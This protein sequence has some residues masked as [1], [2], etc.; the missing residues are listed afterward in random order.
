MPIDD[1]NYSKVRNIDIKMKLNNI[2]IKFT[3]INIQEFAS[4]Q[5]QLPTY[6]Y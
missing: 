4:S 6:R 2:N 5:N 3:L 1:M